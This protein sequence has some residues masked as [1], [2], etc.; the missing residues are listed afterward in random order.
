MRGETVRARCCQTQRWRAF[1]YQL[2]AGMSPFPS[3]ETSHLTTAISPA[4]IGQILP[5]DVTTRDSPIGS[6]GR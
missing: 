1:A 4:V 3:P 5:H 6:N 2:T